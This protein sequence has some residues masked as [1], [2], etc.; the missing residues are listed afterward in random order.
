MSLFDTDAFFDA[1]F[2]ASNATRRDPLPP[3]DAVLAQVTKLDKTGGISGEGK[4]WYKLNVQWTISD[5]DYLAK[6]GR[7]KATITQGIMLDVTDAGTIA[8]GPNTNIGLG[9]FREAVGINQ[10]G[11]SLNDAM[12]QYGKIKIGHRPDPKDSSIVYDEVT[13]VVKA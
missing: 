11:K 13:G 4:A 10:P 8:M 5:P 2:E 3:T 7:E 6:A 1:Q 9:R 12:G